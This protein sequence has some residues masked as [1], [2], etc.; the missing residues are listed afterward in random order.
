MIH[1]DCVEAIIN[2]SRVSRRDV[3]HTDCVE[4]IINRSRVSGVLFIQ[5]V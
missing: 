2:R 1:T 4:A 3:I 5:I